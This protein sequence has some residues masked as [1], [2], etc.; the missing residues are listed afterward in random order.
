MAKRSESMP[1]PYLHDSTQDIAHAYGAKRTPEFFLFDSELKL[2]YKGRM[3]DS[4]RNPTMV[5]SNE[6]KDAVEA[7]LAG[8]KPAVSQTESI[9]C[10]VK[11]K[12]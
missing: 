6:L 4:P 3:D 5:Q 2:V 7:M 10:S 9:G 1:Y 11:W 8:E 12:A